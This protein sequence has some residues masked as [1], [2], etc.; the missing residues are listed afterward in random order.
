MMVRLFVRMQERLL[1]PS[2]STAG[3]CSAGS[4]TLITDENLATA[5]RACLWSNAGFH[6]A[7]GLC[8]ATEYGPMPDWNTSFLTDA[9]N[10]FI[11]YS[12]FNSD[13]SDW[14]TSSLTKTCRMFYNADSFNQTFE[15]DTSNLVDATEM[16]SN[17]AAFNGD[18]RLGYFPAREHE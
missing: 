1:F 14:D 5:I 6:L 13:I 17:A 2:S 16:F 9:S 8:I 10:V 12:E 3:F 11:S 4:K 7:D 18:M 15:M